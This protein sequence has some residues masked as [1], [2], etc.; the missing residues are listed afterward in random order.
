MAIENLAEIICWK[1]NAQP[2]TQFVV[3][4]GLIRFWAVPGVQQPT[5]AEVLAFEPAWLAAGGAMA[6]F[7]KEA[8]NVVDALQATGSM[9]LRAVVIE[10]LAY[11]NAQREYEATIQTKFNSLLT[12]LGG[13]AQLTLKGQL[14]AMALPTAPAQATPSQAKTALKSRINA[15]E[16]D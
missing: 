12:W 10:T 3:G 15:G 8:A 14:P 9:A 7:R 6:R 1:W 11:A 16:A 13:Q 5:E 2:N 4:D